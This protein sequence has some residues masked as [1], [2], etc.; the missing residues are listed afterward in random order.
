MQ[1]QE[2]LGL[3][4]EYVN[5]ESFENFRKHLDPAW[6]ELAIDASGTWTVRNRR[7]PANQVVW[8]VIGM[9]LYRGR[10]IEELVDKLELAGPGRDGASM[11]PSSIS[12]ARGKVGRETLEWL[13]RYSGLKWGTKSADDHRFHGLSVY[14]VDGT[15]LRVA[16]SASNRTYFGGTKG[17]RGP[18]AYPLVRIV[19]LMALRSHVLVAARLGPYAKSESAY[20]RELWDSVPDDSVTVL[21]RLFLAAG[22][23]IP[24]ASKGKNRHW[25][26][27][28]K[29]N[30]RYR[31]IEKLSRG[32]EIV[33]IDV[34][35]QAQ[36]ADPSLPKRWRM[37]A[38]Q[39]QKKGFQPQVL[40]TSLLDAKQYPA[41]EIVALYHERWELELGFNEIKTEMLEREETLRSKTPARVCQEAWGVLIA[42]NL[43]RLEME[44]VADELG[45]EPT[46]ISFVASLREIRD[47]WVWLEATKPGAIPLRLKK[48]R[49]RIKRFILP[50]RRTERAYPRAV[51]IK[52]S[53]YA[54]KR[55]APAA[56]PTGTG[57]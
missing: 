26:T 36:K 48:L 22:T 29:K 49:A 19:A 2:A 38:I 39:Y 25:L 11:A 32:D 21:D 30:T 12:E 43:I 57:T 15:S 54:K 41:S 35:V 18:S 17:S 53:A 13:F 50:P 44:R 31:V 8:L 10:P 47:E 55:P 28:A 9:G 37:R 56:P 24:L 4:A 5:P 52:M 23:L 7:L 34:S 6:I 51:K 3:T 1:L 33:E 20:A 14:G 42:Y 27:R 16:D 40:L 46:R 45:I